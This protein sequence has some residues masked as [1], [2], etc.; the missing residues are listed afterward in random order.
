MG[1]VIKVDFNAEKDKKDKRNKS[2]DKSKKKKGK[3]IRANF[4]SLTEKEFFNFPLEKGENIWQRD[5]PALPADKIFSQDTYLF[6]YYQTLR[7]KIEKA[8]NLLADINSLKYLR[9][10]LGDLSLEDLFIK[11]EAASEDDFKKKP[12]YYHAIYKEIEERIKKMREDDKN[13]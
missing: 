2:E 3:V 7:K 6:Y 10:Q 13:K 11:L 12:T 4:K 5:L 9:N 8:K 1:E